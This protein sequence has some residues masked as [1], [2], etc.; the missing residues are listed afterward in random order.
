MKKNMTTTGDVK[1]A[2]EEDLLTLDVSTGEK[3]YLPFT[4]KTFGAL[5]RR[6]S[7]CAR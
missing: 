5:R 3:F 7:T 6:P 4:P 1:I 2:S